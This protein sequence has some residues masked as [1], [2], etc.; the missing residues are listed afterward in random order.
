[1]IDKKKRESLRL[2]HKEWGGWGGNE[3]KGAILGDAVPS[4]IDALD[5]AD[6]EISRLKAQPSQVELHDRVTRYEKLNR[7]L[8][9]EIRA[10]H[11]VI[12][13]FAM[14]FYGSKEPDA[15][16]VVKSIIIANTKLNQCVQE[17]RH[18]L[19]TATHR[20]NTFARE[21]QKLAEPLPKEPSVEFLQCMSTKDDE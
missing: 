21:L 2:L 14:N 12:K 16:N 7:K 13:G 1:M 9:G 3:D 11:A 19:L 4:L 6:L 5:A 20:A 10:L 18:D 17:L 8:R 15:H